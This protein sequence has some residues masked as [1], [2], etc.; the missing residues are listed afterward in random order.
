[1][2]KTDVKLATS[3]MTADFARMGE[4]LAEVERA[5]A[6]RIHVDIMDGHFVPNISGGIPVIR[7]LTKVT[8]LPVE[9]HL[10]I[11]HPDVLLEAFIDAGASS[12]LVH[13]EGNNNLARTLHRIKSLGKH[14]G[15][16]VN[17]AT[18]MSVL[19]EILHDLDEVLILTVTPGLGHQTF[20]HSTLAKIAIAR[21]LIDEMNPA[22]ELGVEGGIDA[23]TAPMVFDAGANV[24]VV[25]SAVFN[26]TEG[27]VESIKKLRDSL[28][29]AGHQE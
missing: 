29:A 6:D 26:Q 7:W 3:L 24:L 21:E 9:A 4:Q 23:E 22:C 13:W 19:E 20:M 5:G 8:R 16:A 11:L 10:M 12:L 28:D 25:G 2:N 1:M 15:V 17:P 18:P 14:A 27:V